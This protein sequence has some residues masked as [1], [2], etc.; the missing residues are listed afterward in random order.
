MESTFP[1]GTIYLLERD[2]IVVPSGRHG[3]RLP[4]L[5]LDKSRKCIPDWLNLEIACQRDMEM[6]YGVDTTLSQCTMIE[7]VAHSAT[8]Y[9]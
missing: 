4:Q 2:F 6:P 8:S 9:D 1:R 7:F 5:G 3:V